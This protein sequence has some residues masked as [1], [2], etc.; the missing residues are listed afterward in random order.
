MINYLINAIL[1]L[2]FPFTLLAMI[3]YIIVY[4]SKSLTFMKMIMSELPVAQLSEDNNFHEYIDSQDFRYSLFYFP[5]GI[6]KIYFLTWTRDKK[7]HFL[8]ILSLKE[9][10]DKKIEE[11]ENRLQSISEN[12]YEKYNTSDKKEY[13]IELLQDQCKEL[14]DR[15]KIAQFKAGFYL[16]TL[17]LAITSIF[18]NIHDT[19]L[20]L[21]WSIYKQVIFGLIVLY[22]IN[23]IILLFGFIS[24]KGYK[25]ER[26]STFRDSSQE[27]RLFYM[28]W[29]KKFQRLQVYTDRDISFILNIENYLKL[30]IVWS[31]IF[32]SLSI[33]QGEK[34]CYKNPIYQ[35]MNSTCKIIK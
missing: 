34:Q 33:F 21:N 2:Y 29:Y 13:H 1:Y 15:E 9:L 16:T 6:Y 25:T 27:E 17:V 26:Y 5:I 11:K 14:Q 12:S 35:D 20:I 19:N 32:M 7:F 4:E 3:Y 8:K 18:K 30:I 10:C 24:V 23:V 28:Y 31:I 22:I